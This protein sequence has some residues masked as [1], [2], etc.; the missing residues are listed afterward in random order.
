MLKVTD[1]AIRSESGHRLD[2]LTNK[3]VIWGLG[4]YGSR[5]FYQGV[6]MSR[7]TKETRTKK[8]PDGRNEYGLDLRIRNQGLIGVDSKI[9]LKDA[10][11][12]SLLYTPGVA[13]PCLEIA[14]DPIRSFDLTCRGNTIAVISDGSSVYG[15]GSTGPESALA[16]LE[17][18]GSAPGRRERDLCVHP[19][20]ARINII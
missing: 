13:A 2:N 14:D 19:G 1:G 8:G 6:K 12:L 10:S 3:S 9:P 4:K 15:L 7:K 17:G 11:A 20:E 18:S 5:N 16:M